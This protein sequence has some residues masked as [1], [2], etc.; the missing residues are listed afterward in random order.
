MTWKSHCVANGAVALALT[1][2][3]DVA[4]AAMATAALPDQIEGALPL[5]K[6]RGASH[7]VLLW[8]G[9]IVAAPAYFHHEWPRWLT[10][11]P[12]PPFHALR[13]I[14]FALGMAAFGLALGPLLACSARWLFVFGRAGC[15]V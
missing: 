15:T 13:G 6:H 7:W 4:L 1:C 14:R 3:Y 10:A 5:G 12:C 9:V 2:R 11:L 8:L